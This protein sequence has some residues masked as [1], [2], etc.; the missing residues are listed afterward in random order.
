MKKR[1]MTTITTSLKKNNN[2]NHVIAGKF[3]QLADIYFSKGQSQLKFKATALKAAAKKIKD[4]PILITT[5][6]IAV[7]QVG[8]S[9]RMALKIKEIL[10]TG[11][12]AE[13]DDQM[14]PEVANDATD[15]TVTQT[16]AITELCKITGIGPKKAQS[17]VADGYTS[18]AALRQ[19]VADGKLKLTH[20][21]NVG[22]TWYEDLLLRMPR[23]EVAQME[24]IIKA[25]A[26]KI[27]PDITVMIAG[28]YRRGQPTCGDVDV[29]MTNKK[30]LDEE[31]ADCD[32]LSKIVKE[33]ETVGFIKD[34][35][36]NGPK[37]YMG[38]CQLLGG[39]GRRIDIRMMNYENFYAGLLYFT[40]NASFNIKLRKKAMELGLKLNEYSFEK[41]STGEKIIVHSEEE[42]FEKL[43]VPYVTP[44]ERNI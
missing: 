16:S 29:L 19:G 35:L 38:V 27:D 15:N 8:I 34:E 43:G 23:E 9:E 28:S 7:Q 21:I 5:P 11:L 36:A 12:L 13:L 39:K 42:I 18:I 37:K 3:N 25:A 31:I 4:S 41:N 10:D 24:N 1:A 2:I 17:L 26:K 32:Y 44:T 40:G 20:H 30:K 33:L 6:E 22:L 14:Q